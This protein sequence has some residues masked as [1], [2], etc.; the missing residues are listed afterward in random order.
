MVIV[1]ILGAAVLAYG[2]IFAM[3]AAA[4]DADDEM[5]LP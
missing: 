1:I 5:G 3:V 4:S 2:L